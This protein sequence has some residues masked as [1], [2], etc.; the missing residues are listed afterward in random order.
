MVYLRTMSLLNFA[1]RDHTTKQFVTKS[2]LEPLSIPI[3]VLENCFQIV[4]L[5]DTTW[6]VRNGSANTTCEYTHRR[7]YQIDDTTSQQNCTQPQNF[8]KCVLSRMYQLIYSLQDSCGELWAPKYSFGDS[9]VQVELECN[10]SGDQTSSAKKIF[11]LQM[12]WCDTPIKYLQVFIKSTP[13]RQTE[14]LF[15]KKIYEWILSKFTINDYWAMC[16][17]LKCNKEE[18]HINLRD[19]EKLQDSNYLEEGLITSCMKRFPF[20]IQMCHVRSHLYPRSELITYFVPNERIMFHLTVPYVLPFLKELRQET[21]IIQDLFKQQVKPIAPI[22]CDESSWNMLK[23]AMSNHPK[24]FWLSCH[25]RKNAF[26]LAGKSSRPLRVSASQLFTIL[27]KELDC[28]ILMCCMSRNAGEELS[29]A[30]I[31]FVVCCPERLV[32]DVGPVFMK[33]FFSSKGNVPEKFKAG[34]SALS[35]QCEQL[36]NAVVKETGGGYQ[37]SN[38]LKFAVGISIKEA[39]NKQKLKTLNLSQWWLCRLPPEHKFHGQLPVK[40][41]LLCST[42][43]GMTVI[44]H[45]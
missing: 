25:G 26:Y 39:L 14:F 33:G 45:S 36:P 34:L 20:R 38:T 29:K 3:S 37:N 16:L 31:P 5:T 7:V 24:M 40:L 21:R 8:L 28:V 2:D 4:P 44:S 10:L 18:H 15:V 1:V 9:W 22:N 11:C 30:G 6:L 12:N 43:E 23:D 35:N 27:P 41:D 13:N 32:D 42:K 17:N 19:L